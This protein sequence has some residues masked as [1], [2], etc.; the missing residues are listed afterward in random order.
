MVLSGAMDSAMREEV[1]TKFAIQGLTAMGWRVLAYDFPQS[2]STFRLRATSGTGGGS[3]NQGSIIPDV[4]AHKGRTVII[5]ESKPQEDRG[6]VV[7]LLQLRDQWLDHAASLEVLIEPEAYDNVR[8]GICIGLTEQSV[9]PLSFALDLDFVL[10]IQNNGSTV[11]VH[12]R[13]GSDSLL[14]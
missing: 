11:V 14:G 1:I 3:K 2:G 5:I 7:K 9:S 12:E 8:F 13:P 4:V 6:D 10:G